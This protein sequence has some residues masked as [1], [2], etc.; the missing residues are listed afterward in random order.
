MNVASSTLVERADGWALHISSQATTAHPL[1]HELRDD[2]TQ[3]YPAIDLVLFPD[4]VNQIPEVR[5]LPVLATLLSCANAAWSLLRTTACD[6]SQRPVEDPSCNGGYPYVA[7]AWIH[8]AYRLEWHNQTEENLLALSRMIQAKFHAPPLPYG[9]RCTV[10]PYRS[11]FGR[12]GY[13]GLG[14]EFVGKGSDTES[15]LIAGTATGEALAKALAH[16][17]GSQTLLYMR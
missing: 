12:Q 10:S 7:G 6:A 2:G 9:V 15:A 11:W 13:Y 14:L 8:L 4:R 1:R 16:V 3:C 5:A 17:A